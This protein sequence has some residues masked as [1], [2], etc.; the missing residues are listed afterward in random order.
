MGTGVPT[1]HQGSSRDHIPQHM[2]DREAH[3]DPGRRVDMAD[4]VRGLLVRLRLPWLLRHY[5]RGPVLA[6][7]VFLNSCISVTAVAALAALANTPFLFP[8]LAPVAF[9]VFYV[10]L[11]PAAS[12][13]NAI[14]GHAIAIGA[15]LVGLAAASLFG[16]TAAARPDI[17]RW[18]QV[19]AVA[20]ALGLTTGLMVLLR[21]PHMPAGTTAILVALGL[22]RTPGQWILLLGGVLLIVGQ[23]III[24][25]LAGIPYPLWGQAPRRHACDLR[26]L[27]GPQAAQEFDQALRERT[28]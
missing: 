28:D 1:V 2:P 18:S 20:L 17:I 4:V 8:S 21:T 6:A 11:A 23:A 10:P 15:G 3:G 7:F 24:N 5:Q 12:P 9:L 13:R 27:S 25:R 19:V 16:S 22:L 26:D 14:L